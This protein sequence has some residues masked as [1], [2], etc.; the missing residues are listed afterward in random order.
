MHACDFIIDNPHRLLIW[1]KQKNESAP[2]KMGWREYYSLNHCKSWQYVTQENVISAT[3]HF[4]K[5]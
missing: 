1:P 2:G 5:M 3:M 4:I